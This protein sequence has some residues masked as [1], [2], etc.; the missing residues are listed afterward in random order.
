MN[1]T[2]LSK[3]AIPLYGDHEW[4]GKCPLK[5]AEADGFSRLEIK[6]VHYR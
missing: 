5:A 2:T 4:R 3:H 6:E 1:L